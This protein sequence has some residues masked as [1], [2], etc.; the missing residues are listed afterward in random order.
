MPFQPHLGT[1]NMYHLF[2]CPEKNKV[3]KKRK[4]ATSQKC[5]RSKKR[6]TYSLHYFSK[7][8]LSTNNGLSNFAD[9]LNANESS[10]V[11]KFSPFNIIADNLSS[12]DNNFLKLNSSE[13][14]FISKSSN[15]YSL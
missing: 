13:Q 11:S 1:I 8:D 3:N 2:F 5:K 6:A 12:L 14:P 7:Q 9:D 4:L 15:S 10:S